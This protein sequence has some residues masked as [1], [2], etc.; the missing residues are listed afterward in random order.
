[1]P[2]PS[3]PT[4][5]VSLQKLLAPLNA[6]M[7]K[8]AVVDGRQAGQSYSHQQPQESSY[9]N[10]LATQPPEF[11]EATDPLE[12]NHWLRVTESKIGLLHCTEPQKTL[13]V[14]QQLRGSTSAWWDSYTTAL[15]NDHGTL[16]LPHYLMIIRFH[17]INFTPPS[18]L[19]IYLQVYSTAS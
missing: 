18:V 19:T 13:F 10:F 8:L 11:A 2:P 4:P 16:T 7:Q 3:P 6:I 15:P 12:A 5:P 14:A 17:G 9:F 1:V